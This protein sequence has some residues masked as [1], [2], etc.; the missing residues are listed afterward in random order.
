MLTY[1]TFKRE[2]FNKLGERKRN[3][4]FYWSLFDP[5]SWEESSQPKHFPNFTKGQSSVVNILKCSKAV[6]KHTK[7]KTDKDNFKRQFI[8]SELLTNYLLAAEIELKLKT[9]RLKGSAD[10]NNLEKTAF[11]DI[12][13]KKTRIGRVSIEIKG[14]IGA[15]RLT[16]R[17]KDEVVPK[18]INNKRDFNNFLLLILFPVCKQ[19]SGMRVEELVGGYYVFEDLLTK[20]GQK[21]NRKVLSKAIQ[22]QGNKYTL[23]SIACRVANFIKRKDE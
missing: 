22:T 11:P 2:V 16:D 5:S 6:K 13:I 21:L 1:K 8:Y 19:E 23:S 20:S 14:K 17:I 7:T 4:L 9:S 12:I 10:V 18:V 3:T 15:K